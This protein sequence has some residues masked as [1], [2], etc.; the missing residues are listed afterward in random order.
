MTKSLKHGQRLNEQALAFPLGA[1][2]FTRYAWDEGFRKVWHRTLWRR[3]EGGIQSSWASHGLRDQRVGWGPPRADVWLTAVNET[4]VFEPIED[5]LAA[6]IDMRLRYGQ[7]ERVR[8]LMWCEHER[9]EQEI[10]AS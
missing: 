7:H 3:C 9:R 1:L 5:A 10:G 8:E 4:Q 6:E 2:F